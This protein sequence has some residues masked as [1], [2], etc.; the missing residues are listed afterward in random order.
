VGSLQHDEPRREDTAAVLI[1][2]DDRVVLVDL[3]ER[4]GPVVGLHDPIALRPSFHRDP[5]APPS[6]AQTLPAR[7][8][9][10]TAPA[11]P[12]SAVAAATDPPLGLGT[13]LV[14][15]QAA[16]TQLI[17]I[18][19]SGR[20]LRLVVGCHLDECNPPR[21]ARRGIAHDAHGFNRTRLAEELL[22]L[23]LAGGVR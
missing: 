5:M 21:A 11:A 18:E 8:A 22:Q 6:D 20:L 23:C 9:A 10:S 1:E 2:I 19:F 17:L 4:A 3:D 7:L 13:R 12:V 15:R 14:A 16:A